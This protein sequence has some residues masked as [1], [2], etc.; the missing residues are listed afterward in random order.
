MTKQE[1]NTIDKVRLEVETPSINRK[2]MVVNPDGS[3]GGY[4]WIASGSTIT[5]D[6]GLKLT[7]A[8][9]GATSMWSGFMRVPANAAVAAQLRLVNFT[10]ARNIKVQINF[11]TV[12]RAFISST[13]LSGAMSSAGTYTVS[14]VAPANAAYARIFIGLYN[15]SGVPSAG[16]Y[17]TVTDVMF[18]SDTDAVRTN[19]IT[20]PSFETN[21]NSWSNAFFSNIAR[22]NVTSAV[23]GSYCASA[24]ATTTGDTGRG[25]PTGASGMPV[26]AEK[27][28]TFSV[29]SKAAT[30]GREIFFNFYWYN[31]GNSLIQTDTTEV[32]GTDSTSWQRFSATRTAPVGAV[33]GAVFIIWKAT[34]NAEVHYFDCAMYEQASQVNPYFDGSIVATDT[35]NYA[36]TGTAH[37]STSTASGIEG[38][39][40]RRWN[41]IKN[42]SFE[43]STAVGWQNNVSGLAATLDTSAPAFGTKSLRVAVTGTGTYTA[44]P[45]TL[46][47]HTDPIMIKGGKTYTLSVHYKENAAG[48]AAATGN[49]RPNLWIR[50]YALQGNTFGPIPVGL[51]NLSGIHNAPKFTPTTSWTRQQYT[52][53][54]PQYATHFEVGVTRPGMKPGQIIWIDGVQF[55]EGLTATD[56]FD[57]STPDSTELYDW[58]SIIN[59]SHSTAYTPGELAYVS[60]AK[61][62]VNVLG[63]AHEITIDREALNLGMMTADFPLADGLDPASTPDLLAKGREVR[64]MALVEPFEWA[65]GQFTESVW[66]P[67]FTGNIDEVR[68]VYEFNKD[69]NRNETHV[70]LNAVDRTA[71]LANIKAP[72]SVASVPELPRLLNGAN[73]PW[74]ANHNRGQISTATTV[75]VIEDASALDQIAI[76]RDTNRGQAWV[77]RNGVLNVFNRSTYRNTYDH[78]YAVNASINTVTRFNCTVSV[79]SD[80]PGVTVARATA[81]SSNPATVEVLLPAKGLNGRDLNIRTKNQVE[82]TRTIELQPLDHLGNPTSPTVATHTAVSGTAS[83]AQWNPIIKVPDGTASIRVR[84]TMLSMVAGEWFNVYVSHGH[85]PRCLDESTKD[86]TF[87]GSGAYVRTGYTDMDMSFSTS[88]LINSVTFKY[89]RTVDGQSEEVPYGP[90]IDQSSIDQYG[91]A[92]YEF[93][94]VGANEGLIDFEALALEI[95]TANKT[96][97]RKVNNVTTLVDNNAGIFAAVSTDLCDVVDVKFNSTN[98]KLRVNSIK[99]ILKAEA[100]NGADKST[101]FVEY[102]FGTDGG[103]ALPQMTA[104]P[105][106][107]IVYQTPYGRV[108]RHNSAQGIPNA[109]WT[110]VTFNTTDSKT[111]EI[112]WD[113][114]NQGYV[115]DKP[116][117]YS[118]IGS[119]RWVAG[120]AGIRGIAVYRNG[121][122]H[123]YIYDIETNTALTPS[124]QVST[125]VRLN[126]GDTIDLRTYQ[127]SGSALNILSEGSGA[128]ALEIGWIGP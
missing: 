92:G 91:A 38:I 90:Y 25:T 114:T 72:N 58:G 32:L 112:T 44:N 99:H 48:V 3:L 8:A 86:S 80:P 87:S 82:R 1:F 78:G 122:I 23:Y 127:S 128:T 19:L 79:I 62:Y 50:W 55:E 85:E 9:G 111:G 20:N 119:V 69:K 30:T 75:A 11:F 118:V 34:A 24:T 27:D 14:G 53:T 115:I 18:L 117:L 54:A 7:S 60:P 51:A 40:S 101:W 124:T 71:Q 105:N 102:G 73:V 49:N 22:T 35:M 89:L 67:I 109:A 65:T 15:G 4:W 16:N 21:A 70:T 57:G 84:I 126:A 47:S 42:P 108:K 104:S 66:T 97:I 52:L 116:G 36:W 123:R 103:T 41:L 45:R 28:Y 13:P 107:T 37:A 64:V 26:T 94:I 29:Y 46:V 106:G 43:A 31:A 17:A 83:Y 93:K 113:G 121:V 120:A 100:K 63:S 74:N 95:L 68:S 98:Y 88:D 5:T 61:D 125:L 12:G 33:R 56:Y 6:G 10:A 110:Q 77:D 39:G 59:N 2:N 96:P 76:T 81:V